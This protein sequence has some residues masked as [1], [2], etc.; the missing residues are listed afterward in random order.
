M[1]R[2][3]MNDI[4]DD[5]MSDLMNDILSNI[6]SES[7]HFS[8]GTVHAFFSLHAFAPSIQILS[9]LSFCTQRPRTPR[10]IASWQRFPH[11]PD[12]LPHNSSLW[13]QLPFTF[14][15]FHCNIRKG[16]GLESLNLEVLWKMALRPRIFA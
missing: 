9:A 1:M 8:S 3:V 6:M 4:M 2:D 14:R 7:W 11:C 15:I 16:S 10:Q 13:N 12:P 5:I